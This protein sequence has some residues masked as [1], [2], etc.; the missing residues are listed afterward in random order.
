[1]AEQN[2]SDEIKKIT[3]AVSITVS[4]FKAL[5]KELAESQAFQSASLAEQRKMQAHAITL[6]KSKQSSDSDIK[7]K[8]ADGIANSTKSA[9]YLAT[10]ASNG[11]TK[12]ERRERENREKIALKT[13]AE[14][15][16]GDNKPEKSKG[17][18]GMIKSLGAGIGGIASSFLKFG[19]FLLKAAFFPITAISAMLTSTA[20]L[21]GGLVAIGALFAGVGVASFMLSDKEFEALK[22]KIAEGVAGVFSTIVEGAIDFYNK[23]VP[24]SFK[25]S[26]EDKKS[27]SASVFT[28]VKDGIISIIDF[29]KNIT[30]AFTEGFTTNMAGIKTKFESFASKIGDVYEKIKGWVSKIDGKE[31]LMS[32][33]KFMGDM[34][35]KFI[36][37]ILTVANFIADL[38]LD[39]QVTL[40]KLQ[41]SVESL[42]MD[43]GRD[44]SDIF[45]ELFSK[46]A[47]TK[48]LHNAFPMMAKGMEKFGLIDSMEEVSKQAAERKKEEKKVFEKRQV[49]LEKNSKET[50][51]QLK[52]EMDKGEKR[53]D[54]TVRNL[55]LVLEREKREI[56]RNEM[57]LKR[58]ND[59]ISES[60]KGILK[61][62]VEKELGEKQLKLESENKQLAADIAKMQSGTYQKFVD[63]TFQDIKGAKGLQEDDIKAKVYETST[64]GARTESF[65]MTDYEKMLA[66]IQKKGF[67]E[68]Q[69]AGGKVQLDE[70]TIAQLM[71]LNTGI[72]EDTFTN[73]KDTS[74]IFKAGIDRLA[75]VEKLNAE[76]AEKQLTIDSTAI[77]LEKAR[78]VETKKQLEADPSL[79]HSGG[80]IKTSGS[81]DLVAGEMVMDNKSAAMMDNAAQVLTAYLPASGQALNQLEREKTSQNNGGGT[82]IANT[83]ASTKQTVVNNYNG[84]NISP[85]AQMLSG[86]SSTRVA[87]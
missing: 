44:I 38:I 62:R 76:I 37:G 43:I 45:G 7:K 13:S 3:K 74:K 81:Y 17:F 84:S 1:M 58:V 51:R 11:E 70:D 64:F 66:V 12:E 47:M 14:G 8:L 78:V 59:G 67:T 39:P 23:F 19:G 49:L 87:G 72:D 16:P 80:P 63:G 73:L 86:E 22:L 77:T 24:D 9:E 65:S 83:D 34:L 46:E 75:E 52:E 48:F 69:L 35:G 60:K 4:E 41:V 5:K 55:A 54:E 29:V 25:I 53:N 21:V 85:K 28:T 27:M 71:R 32:Y 79:R 18:L 20:A 15:K 2:N 31:G 10:I 33:V 36:S 57:S 6:E 50:A 82:V 42:F 68:E 30:D 40:A 56:T 26:E 61:A